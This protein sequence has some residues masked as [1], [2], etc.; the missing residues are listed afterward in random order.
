MVVKLRLAPVYWQSGVGDSKYVVILDL[1]LGHVI[2]YNAFIFHSQIRLLAIFVECRRV[3][4]SGVQI[5]Y[6]IQI[7]LHV[8]IDKYSISAN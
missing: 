1:T 5:I 6:N 8:D 2:G 4:L 7:I 3:R